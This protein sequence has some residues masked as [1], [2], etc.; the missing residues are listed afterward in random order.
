VKIQPAGAELS[1]EDGQDHLKLIVAFRTIR[2]RL[3]LAH[4]ALTVY[5]C[6]LYGSENKQRLFHYTA[7]TDW[8]L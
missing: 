7:L 6:V 8:F 5:L 1:H 4:T 3:K 2:K